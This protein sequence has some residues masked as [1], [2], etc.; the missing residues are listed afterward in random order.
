M[1]Y[2]QNL[3]SPE[4]KNV[5]TRTQSRATSNIFICLLDH[6]CEVLLANIKMEQ[7]RRLEKRLLRERPGTQ[8]IAM[9]TELLS[10]YFGVHL[11]ESYCK[12]FN[13]SDTNWLRYLF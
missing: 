3:E 6:A 5:L 8:Q 1:C 2:R 9:V 10:S 4:L 7:Q 13:I 11:A 12:E